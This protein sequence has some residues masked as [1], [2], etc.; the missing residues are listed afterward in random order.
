MNWGAPEWLRALAVPGLGCAALVALAVFRRRAGPIAWP[1]ISRVLAAGPRVRTARPERSVRRPWLLLAA[2]ACA[3]LAL[4]RPRWGSIEEPRVEHAREIMLALDLSKSMLA[5]DVAPNRLA[6]SKLLVQGLLAGLR[7]ERIGLVVFAGTSFVQVP[8]S[9]DYQILGEFLDGLQP[10]TMPQGGTDY[11]GMLAA[12]LGAF[13]S[14]P[15][16]DRF[17]VVLSDGES[18]AGDWRKHVPELVKRGVRAL[19]LGIG[20]ERGA[21]V[22]DPKSGY[23]KDA[24]GAV[25]LSRL[26]PATLR[27]LASATGGAYRDASVWVDLPALLA[28]TVERGRTHAFTDTRSVRCIERFQWLLAPALAFAFLALWREVGARVR[29]RAIERKPSAAAPARPRSEAAAKAAGFT[30]A[31]LLLA[32]LGAGDARARAADT[33]PP[34]PAQE[35]RATVARLADAPR[36]HARDWSDLAEKTIAYGT[37]TLSAGQ[38]LRAGAIR[39]ALEAVDLGERTDPAAADWPSLRRRLEQLLEPP[40]SQQQQQQPKPEQQDQKQDDQSQAEKQPSPQPQGGG[41]DRENPPPPQN[42]PQSPP[43]TNPSGQPPPPSN[44]QPAPRPQGES[45]GEFAPPST[46]PPPESNPPPPPPK[47]RRIGGRPVG[48][49]QPRPKT[50]EEAAVL[51]RLR[52]ATDK[53][54]PARLFELLEGAGDEP[55]PAKDW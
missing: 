15:E 13:G 30:A 12:A 23:V 46:P 8:A 43:P 52:Q 47:T 29:P 2:L 54:S 14:D 9:A 48:D 17:L 44:G 35:V 38:P 31:A 11:A 50:P 6:R 21:L 28:E 39:D 16:A 34:D 51:Q 49:G 33:T 24:R 22:P 4:A 36:R 10:S 40:P 41:S 19:A 37:A 3:I 55:P 18:L 27:E 7:G 53:D 1:A 42:Q 45:L 25:V 26:E 32:A 20:T 5:E